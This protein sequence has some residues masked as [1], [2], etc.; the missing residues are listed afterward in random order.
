MKLAFVKMNGAAN[1]FIMVDNRGGAIRLSRETVALLCDRRRGI[2]ADGLIL[3]EPDRAHDFF[4]HYFNADGGEE[5]MCGNGARCAA[6]FGAGLGLG[7]PEP[8]ATTIHF[9]T[10]SGVIDARVSGGNVSMS[11]MDARGMRRNLATKVAPR[12][13]AVHFMVVGTRHAV[14]P[15]DDAT[16]LT[17]EEVVQF[18]RA[19]RHDPAF[20][21]EGANVN[22]ASLAPDGRIYLRTYE[23][24]IEGETLACGTGSVASAVIFAHEGRVK[25]P[26][27][28]LQHSGD[29]L[30]VSF[31]PGPDGAGHVRMEGPV[32][33]S[34]RGSV[35]V[36]D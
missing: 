30:L 21:P 18:G 29:E 12:A 7:R 23:K 9:L 27:R 33:V 24:G 35:D 20:A 32:M 8:S 15:L 17:A 3:I 36:Q 31:E 25:S 13:A 22:F 14:V 19:L 2:G 6:H 34:F 11:M 26:V 1:D 5:V 4:M 28:V 16:T 10:G